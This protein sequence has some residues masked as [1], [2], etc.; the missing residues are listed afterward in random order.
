M[1]QMGQ[2]HIGRSSAARMARLRD[3]R[4]R[5]FACYVI[6]VCEADVDRLVRSG[7]LDRQ[8]CFNGCDRS[9]RPR[10]EAAAHYAQAAKQQ[11]EEKNL[12]V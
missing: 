4:R 1:T 10:T 12:H 2:Q 9:L 11:Q 5:G 8:T 7:Y 3:R 6:E